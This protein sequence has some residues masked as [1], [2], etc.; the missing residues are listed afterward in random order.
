MKALSLTEPWATAIALGWKN[1]E[2]RSWPTGFRG[3][4]AIHAAK[5][6]PSW[7]KEIAE[8]H[9]LDTKSL[10]LGC[11]VAVCELTECRQT[12]T[13]APTLPAQELQWGDYAA[14]RYA[15]KLDNV[16]V[17]TRPVFHRG[18]L[19]LWNVAWDETN[20]I[21]R[22]LRGAAKMASPARG[23]KK[24]A[25]GKAPV[26]ERMQQ[27]VFQILSGRPYKDIAFQFGITLSRIAHIRR[28][29]GIPRRL[30][31]AE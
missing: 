10:P 14:G 29:A 2:T 24:T 11:I 3:Q 20:D 21:L 9:G 5:G 22:Q 13:L 7:A 1:W 23:W 28:A 25:E 8:E 17:L 19:G 30:K 27:I 31:P 18:A 6:C 26:D 16:R 15:F 12:E 4:L